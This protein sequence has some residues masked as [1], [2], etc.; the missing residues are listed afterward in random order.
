MPPAF[1]CAV[2]WW[3][4]DR[5]AVVVFW[6]PEGLQKQRGERGASVEGTRRKVGVKMS[7]VVV[8]C[9]GFDF[10]RRLCFLF[11]RPS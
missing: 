1:F 3:I 7:K 8:S 4:E 9:F 10:H 6:G 5:R 2:C 11:E